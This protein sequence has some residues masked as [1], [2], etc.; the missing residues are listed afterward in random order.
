MLILL[1]LLGLVILAYSYITDS[2]RVRGMAEKY[3]SQVMGGKVL[4]G[5]ATLSVFEGLKLDDVK[6]YVDDGGKPD[7]LIFSAKTFVLKYDPG[8]I[9]AGQ[10]EAEQIIA[11]KP[12]VYLTENASTGDWNFNRIGHGQTK[13][14]RPTPE[15][16][17]VKVP[18]LPEVLLRNARVEISEIR[19]G[20]KTVLGYKAIDGQ[21]SP[22]PG[23]GKYAF[24]LQTRGVEGAGPW[25]SGVVA[26]ADGDITAELHNFDFDRDVRSML[27]IVLRDWWER[28]ALSGRVDIPEFRYHPGFNGQ[29]AHFRVETVLNGV[30]ISVPHEDW[31]SADEVRTLG[32]I[33]SAVKA[34]KGLYALAGF[35]VL[36]EPEEGRRHAS[37][38]DA[39][40]AMTE[41]SPIQLKQGAGVFVFTDSGIEVRD[42]AG[43]VENNAFKI[44][45]HMGGYSP[46]APF[47][48]QIS[49]LE[50][51][52]I[53]IP[54]APRYLNS[55]PGIVRD[56][57]TMIHPEGQ[58]RVLARVDRPTPGARPLIDG[59]VDI[60]EGKFFSPVFPYPMRDTSGRIAFGTD[61]KTGYDYVRIIAMRGC[62]PA[63]GPNHDRY[64]QV[65]GQIGPLGPGINDPQVALKVT[66]KDITCDKALR[67]AFPE[68]VK[69]PMKV[70]DADARGDEPTFRG[71]FSSTVFH[72]QGWAWRWTFDTDLD[73]ADGSVKL[74]GFPYPLEHLSGVL[75]VRER[76]IDIVNAHAK[77][78]TTTLVVN[79]R[80]AWEDPDHP[81]DG[82]PM[83]PPGSPKHQPIVRTDVK[84][85]VHDLPVD[86][87]LL[88]A[89]PP[90]ERDWLKKIGATG[91]IDVEGSVFQGIE[92]SGVL[93]GPEP[94]THLPLVA[95][96]EE[97]C[98]DL[99]ITLHD[100]T[101]WPAEGTF[102]V[103]DVSGHL[104]LAQ[105]GLQILDLHGKRG[106]AQLSTEGAIT[107]AGGPPEVILRAHAIDLGMDAPLYAM[108]PVDGRRAWDEVQ[109]QGTIDANMTFRWKEG[110]EDAGTRGRGDAGKEGAK[111]AGTEN[112]ADTGTAEKKVIAMAV[113]PS[114][115]ASVPL[116]ASPRP[117]V[118]ASISVDTH[119]PVPEIPP[120]ADSLGM[121]PMG[122]TA[123][124]KPRGLTCTIKSLPYRLELT[125]GAIRIK[126]GSVTIEEVTGRHGAGT[127]IVSGTGSTA[128]RPVWD[129]R[130]TG[131]DVAVDDEL[132]AAL[133]TA[134]VSVIDS[135][136]LRG[137]IDFDFPKFVYRGD[138]LL[139]STP[140]S[141]P[142]TKAVGN[143]K[144][145]AAGTAPASGPASGPASAPA[146]PLDIDL[147]SVITLNDCTLDAGVPMQN[148]SGKL[149][150]AATVREGKLSAMQGDLD[151][152]KLTMAGHKL[153]GFKADLIKPADRNEFY[154]DKM[155]ATV[156]GGQ[157][158]GQI[159]M[160]Y[161]DDGPSRYLMSMVLRN[162]DAK[163]L[164]ADKDFNGQLTASL[165]LEGAWGDAS[166]RRGRGDVVVTG[167][168]LY[169][170]PLI[171]G[172]L[173]VT[174]LSLPIAMPF[175]TGTARYSVD[176]QRVNFE[177]VELKSDNMMMTGTGHLDFKSKQVL[178]T[179][180]TDN[181]GGFRVPFLNDILQGAR[182]ELFK[183]N[184]KGTIQQPKVE[185]NPFG[186]FTTTIDEVFK[187]DEKKK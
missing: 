169:R 72:G 1:L 124:L 180:V 52:N 101:L 139:G 166:I 71:D 175:K 78:G 73:V 18:P 133:P 38:I 4:V 120:A 75:K 17:Q 129:L 37:P 163:E 44:N 131:K 9:I 114:A 125:G 5:G 181:P 83:P 154:I 35:G 77:R 76:Y 64:I 151:I 153:D 62:G 183:F 149:R 127:M 27:P 138:G 10:L 61:A 84:V 142:A 50:S 156:A 85:S 63:D 42:V 13:W 143:A 23:G 74:V 130:L 103:S 53:V 105:D 111:D 178:M 67:I 12:Y 146:A 58:C 104:H 121:I 187:A 79:G 26:L 22:V 172:L 69:E 29:K 21:L 65:D 177:Q 117:R 82:S 140:A 70:L 81:V 109:P 11:Q 16:Q 108:L 160:S 47:D 87:M 91:R 66:G 28:H 161:P 96:P 43:R 56:I 8:K 128:E 89:M 46:D 36:S 92:H 150:M 99:G 162:A 94:P 116:S 34:V 119:T 98:F 185:A 184:I 31:M 54:A 51:E 3:L 100:G 159:H 173:Q 157:M 123:V 145:I 182:S 171:M 147:A 55:L 155:R 132:R 179:F 25:A 165:A 97:V 2:R 126:P 118:P 33:R 68:E 39:I 167:K 170:I 7:S 152:S 122:F 106:K 136:K 115:P 80:V 41:S 30:T 49:S 135:M 57:Y 102:S 110:E 14:T 141:G 32:N 144:A 176:G 186:T 6:V 168:D 113:G 60:V 86:S 164:T 112:G 40:S 158:A 45:G 19:D 95:R 20:R 24:E 148:V 174:N 15:P 134:L 88:A 48:V 137:N 93:L 59:Q 90:A 107:W